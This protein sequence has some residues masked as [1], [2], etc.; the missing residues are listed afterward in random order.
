MSHT[1]KAATQDPAY[2]IQ[3]TL[4]YRGEC[5]VCRK[6][7]D[8]N[9]FSIHQAPTEIYEEKVHGPLETKDKMLGIF[10]TV[11]MNEPGSAE[12]D[13]LEHRVFHQVAT[14]ADGSFRVFSPMHA[15]CDSCIQKIKAL[16]PAKCHICRHV[17]ADGAASQKT[18]RH[19]EAAAAG[20]DSGLSLT[21]SPDVTRS[22]LDDELTVVRSITPARIDPDDFFYRTLPRATAQHL[23]RGASFTRAAVALAR[24]LEDLHDTDHDLDAHISDAPTAAPV[25][26]HTYT[27]GYPLQDRRKIDFSG[28]DRESIAAIKRLMR[29]DGATNHEFLHAQASMLRQ[30]HEDM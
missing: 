30:H 28:M 29:E 16:S 25:E 7:K 15:A 21:P 12:E 10:K 23:G 6:D 9:I 22:Y 5:N 19:H 4:A 20:T 14:D 24:S 18:Q 1:I 13:A 8:R 27:E 3:R 2:L 11:S 17:L 26:T